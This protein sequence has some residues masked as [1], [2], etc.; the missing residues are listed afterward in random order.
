MSFIF[1]VIGD[2]NIKRH[3]NPVSC[4]DRPMMSGAQVIPCGRVITLAESLK[5]VRAESN[6]VILSCVTNFL[7]GVKDS[8]GHVSVLIEP[9]LSDCLELIRSACLE[10][11]ET[12]YLLCPPMYRT[13]P[14]W[15]REALP[16]VLQKFSEVSMRSKPPNLLLMPSFPTPSYESDGIHLTAYSGLEFVLHLFDSAI[17]IMSSVSLDQDAKNSRSNES[18]R[19]LEDRMVALE[20]DHRRLSREFESKSVIDA[21]LACFHEN[22]RNEDWFVIQG[23]KRLPDLS[24]KEWQNRAL[25]DVKSV[26]GLFLEQEYPLVYVQNVTGQGKDAIVTYQ[27]RMAST[28]HA[29]LVRG[30]FSAFFANGKNTLPPA[31]KGISIRNR[32]SKATPTRISLLRLFGTR[33]EDA[34]PG[35]SFKVLGFDPRPLLKIFTSPED[36]E[37]KVL[38]YNYVEA[39]CSLPS[40]FSDEE[41]EPILKKIS[42]KLKGKLRQLFGVINDD[43][44]RHKH[45]APGPSGS[46]SG[47]GSG[48]GSSS[49]PSSGKNHRKRS[50]TKSP[51]ETNKSKKSSKS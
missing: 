22:L 17:D 3:L 7:T 37:R 34:H 11:E 2:S 21:E 50:A 45:T 51:S 46:A 12:I 8:S 19:V 18:T 30:K 28:D 26:L 35:S 5:S 16:E 32:I 39:I 15:Y 6:V 29:K 20:Q 44:I 14:L 27:V 9:I 38:T 43:M 48:T 25:Q 36:N 10:R 49:R 1:S 23:L 41:L 13:R 33:Y 40:D 42:P 4:R 31:L 47:S 24:G